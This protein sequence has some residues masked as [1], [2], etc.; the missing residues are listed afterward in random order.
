MFDSWLRE[1]KSDWCLSGKAETTVSE[2]CR[3]IKHLHSYYKNPSLT[4]VKQWLQ[5]A[6][7]ASLR[8]KKA[9]SVRALGKWCEEACV[10]YFEWWRQ[11]PLVA[12][13]VLPQVT[14][15]EEIYRDVLSRCVNNRDRALIEVLWSTGLRRSEIER[16]RIEHVDFANGFVVIP[17]SKSNRPRIVPLS[18]ASMR[19]LRRQIRKDTSGCVFKMTGNAIRLRLARLQAPSAHAW[20]RGWAVHSLRRGVSET[21]VK[22]AA[23]WRSGAM[24]SRYTNALS[25]ELAI[26]EFR[27]TWKG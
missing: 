25:G 14:V 21:S 4:D 9:M 2:Y 1:F 26:D 10:E 16:M 8:R 3:Y 24:V 27:N 15:T 22:A 20:R 18:P 5:M 13:P 19:A 23:G 17:T 11:V 12:E 7:G 6:P